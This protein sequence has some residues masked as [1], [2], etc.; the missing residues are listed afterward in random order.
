MSHKVEWFEIQG[1]RV[2]LTFECPACG[3]RHPFYVAPTPWPNEPSRQWPVWEFNGDMERPTFSPSLLVHG[4]PDG[5]DGTPRCHSFV[6]DGRIEYCGDSTHA[7]A[8]K[9]VDLPEI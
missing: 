7:M 1:H 6:R 8:G 5:K 3:Y 4:N 2:G 9:T